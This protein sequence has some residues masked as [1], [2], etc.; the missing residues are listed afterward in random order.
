MGLLSTLGA[1]ILSLILHLTALLMLLKFSTGDHHRKQRKMLTPAFST[2]HL[3]NLVPIFY[4]V[5]R[6]VRVMV[7][8]Q[9]CRDPAHSL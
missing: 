9:K 2:G 5:T 4:E 6:K 8:G 3:R 7:Q 1:H